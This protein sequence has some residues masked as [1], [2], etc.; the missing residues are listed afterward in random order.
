MIKGVAAARRLLAKRRSVTRCEDLLHLSTLPLRKTAHHFSKYHGSSSPNGHLHHPRQSNERPGHPRHAPR[1]RYLSLDG[2]RMPPAVCSPQIFFHGGYLEGRLKP[3]QSLVLHGKSRNRPPA[4]ARLE[5]VQSANGMLRRRRSHSTEVGPSCNLRSDR[6][7][8][9]RSIRRANLCR[10]ADSRSPQCRKSLPK[11]CAYAWD[12]LFAAGHRAHALS[13]FREKSIDS[14]N[15]YRSPGQ[16]RLIFEEF[17]LYQLSL[18][19]TAEPPTKKTP[20]PSSCREDNVARS[21]QT[22][23]PFKPTAAQK[24]RV[25]GEI[26]ADLEKPPR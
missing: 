18:R 19:S 20:S 17:F 1:R 12:F 5:M 6:T 26:A 21:H 4:A 22:H 24:K 2:A 16:Q 23:L 8:G 15:A 25:L 14:L 10:V 13:A 9:S 11:N 7:F 3:G